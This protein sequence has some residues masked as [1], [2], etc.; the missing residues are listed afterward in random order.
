M[1]DGVGNEPP[2][3]SRRPHCLR[4]W[5]HGKANEVL[6]GS[7]GARGAAGAGA[8]ARARLHWIDPPASGAAKVSS[9][10]AFPLRRD[11]PGIDAPGSR[12]SRI[13]TL[14][15]GAWRIA[16][17]VTPR[18]RRPPTP[19]SARKSPRRP[20]PRRRGIRR[21]FPSYGVQG[22]DFNGLDHLRAFAI[23]ER[24]IV[25]LARCRL[26]LRPARITTR[27]GGPRSG[28]AG[29]LAVPGSSRRSRRSPPRTGRTAG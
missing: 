23:P 7:T 25:R 19:R 27:A 10:P 5:R 24:R 26:F 21:R 18:P 12:V 8:A 9:W 3:L 16:E 6:S 4:G 14:A 15:G 28:R 20:R 17:P 11:V 22:I 2:R 1:D 29:L 13:F